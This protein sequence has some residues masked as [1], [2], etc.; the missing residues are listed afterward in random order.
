[1]LGYTFMESVPPKCIIILVILLS[2]WQ[3]EKKQILGLTVWQQSKQLV[4]QIAWGNI[5]ILK[6]FY[7]NEFAVYKN[8]KHLVDIGLKKV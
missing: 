4:V 3:K 2:D 1:M 6:N 5:D 8:I 7:S